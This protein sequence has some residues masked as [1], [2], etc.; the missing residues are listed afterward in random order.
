MLNKDPAQRPSA[1][2]VLKHKWLKGS[3]CLELKKQSSVLDFT[4]QNLMN[5]KALKMEGKLNIA[6]QK[7]VSALMDDLLHNGL[8]LDFVQSDESQ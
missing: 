2:E 7:K 4:S 6:E 8:D 3:L 1:Y 5:R